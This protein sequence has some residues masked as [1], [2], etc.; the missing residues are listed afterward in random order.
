[1]GAALLWAVRKTEGFLL[2][3]DT[4]RF[5][6]V[7]GV[8][9]EIIESAA[10]IEKNLVTVHAL[11]GQSQEITFPASEEIGSIIDSRLSSLGTLL[12]EA[13]HK[14]EHLELAL[15]RVL[16][17]LPPAHKK[18]EFRDCL[19][20]EMVLDIA[21]STHDEVVIIT[22]DAAFYQKDKFENGIAY[23]LREEIE[24]TGANITIFQN[25][26]WYLSTLKEEVLKLDLH[27]VIPAIN[28]QVY[29]TVQASVEK[30]PHSSI[31]LSESKID[32]FLTEVPDDIAIDFRLKY[33]ISELELQEGVMLPEAYGIAEGSA[34]FNI[35][36]SSVSNVQMTGYRI[37]NT[38]GQTVR[39]NGYAYMSG[40]IFGGP[41]YIPYTLR[42]RI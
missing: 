12:K 5:E 33:K 41:R 10:E 31:E 18:E 32:T 17:H 4:T 16:K 28:E 7:N 21:T 24:R 15:Q 22:E 36:S 3:P 1:M 23:L 40:I 11:I 30:S 39:Q 25:I 26:S 35:H 13:A 2:L 34:M 6:I 37:E 9:K 42:K 29:S 19:L 14:N 38:E 20:W 8:K 27:L